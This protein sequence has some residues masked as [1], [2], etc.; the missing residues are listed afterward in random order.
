LA[1]LQSHTQSENYDQSKWCGTNCCLAGAA[2]LL[3]GNQTAGVAVIKKYLPEFDINILYSP[4]RESA[5]A[6]L[7]RVT[8]IYKVAA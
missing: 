6:E 4:N 3:I 1:V 2:G 7:N 5:I 8:E